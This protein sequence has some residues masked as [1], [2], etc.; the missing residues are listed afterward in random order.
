LITLITGVP[1]TGKTAFAVSEIEKEIAKGRTVFVDN[2]TD[3][4]LEHY[5]AGKITDWHCGTWLHI[6]KYNR[7][8][9]T[10]A[11]QS[12]DGND[13]WIPNPDVVR[14]SDTAPLEL[15]CYN[16][17]GQAVGTVPYES[18]KGALL[19]IDEAQRHFRPRPAGSAVPDHVAA[20]EVHRHQ[21]LDI[22]LIT[23][24]AGLI[25]SNVRAL[26]GRHIALRN[27]SLGRF[28]YEWSEVGDIDTKSS[29][30]TAARSRYRIPKHVFSLYKS[31][32]VHTN[33]KHTLP[34][35][36]KALFVI[37]PL[38]AVLI[39]TAFKTIS[40]K[41]Q[42]PAA[43]V[44][45]A[46]DSPHTSSPAEPVPAAFEPWTPPKSISNTHPYDGYSLNI[47]GHIKGFIDGQSKDFYR[48]MASQ[49]GSVFSLNSTDLIEAGYQL[50]PITDCSLKITY[51]DFKS[52]ISC[53]SQGLQASYR[54]PN[55]N[56]SPL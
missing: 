32:D 30:D 24:R 26:C 35:A 15:L 43:D 46:V 10:A 13:N 37:L 51:G 55:A 27:T 45:A 21:G 22:W 49:N 53:G 54:V 56:F 47:T 8:C 40:G 16:P 6:D 12:D 5:R 52:F 28:K 23:Q 44:S 20:L 11:M 3:L 7:T 18:H 2:I 4:Q 19:V 39:F 17:K 14:R 48:L 34:F 33:Q 50:Q 41:F 42:P 1:G 31:A 29:R 25:D 38:M 36:A 9:A